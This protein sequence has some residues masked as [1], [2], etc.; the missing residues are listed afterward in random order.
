[1]DNN[2]RTYQPEESSSYEKKKTYL[3][4]QFNSYHQKKK[5]KLSFI[6]IYLYHT[7]LYIPNLTR[8]TRCT[9]THARTQPPTTHPDQPKVSPSLKI[10]T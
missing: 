10:E 8:Y 9:H 3:N 2:N 4:I 5:K 7:Q 6:Y 1:M